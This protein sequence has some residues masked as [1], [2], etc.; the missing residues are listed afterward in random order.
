MVEGK[1]G[2]ESILY[3]SLI[4]S[5]CHLSSALW[6]IE[7][8]QQ[9]VGFAG[10]SG[11][12]MSLSLAPDGRTFVS[13]ACDA[14]IKLWDVRDSM[15]RQ[16]FIGHESDINAV[17]VSFGAGWAGHLCQAPGLPCAFIPL[18]SCAL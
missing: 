6:D 12:V 8:G 18:W 10:H 16:T 14:S 11:D 1:G 5:S 7:T 17:A 15:C 4:P 3:P 9:T 13:G 2:R